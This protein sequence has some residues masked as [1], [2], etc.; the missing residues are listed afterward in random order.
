[1][2]EPTTTTSTTSTTRG[3]VAWGAQHSTSPLA[4]SECYDLPLVMD[5]L[6]GQPWAAYVPCLPTFNRP[7][8][9][10]EQA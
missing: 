10:G 6:A 4:A 2:R 7:K 1:M 9:P 3:L 5:W 8:P